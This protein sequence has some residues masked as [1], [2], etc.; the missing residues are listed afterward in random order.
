[1]TKA[2]FSVCLLLMSCQLILAQQRDTLDIDYEFFERTHAWD[3][4]GGGRLGFGDFGDMNRSLND[5]GLPSVD[6][7]TRGIIVAARASS[8]KNRWVGECALEYQWANSNDGRAVNGKAV[9]YRDYAIFL[10]LMYDISYRERRTKV[11]P[12]VGLG[13][14]Y[15]VLRIYDDLPGGGSFVQTVNQNV[16]RFRF[17]GTSVPVEIGLAIEQGFRL[18]YTDVF[19]GVRGGYTLRTLRSDWTL[20]G[21]IVT[22]LPK[23]APGA[24]FVAATLRFKTDVKRAWAL[25][26]L[27]AKQ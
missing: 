25:R 15:Q 4:A 6:A 18:W 26:K 13:V 8:E 27:R 1:M 3:V 14:S 19:I 20:D 9:T 24:S 10:R 7:E 5:A 21:D 11:L 12:F 23:S 17:D 16:R 2:L 22:D